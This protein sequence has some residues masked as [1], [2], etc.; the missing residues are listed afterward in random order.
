MQNNFKSGVKYDGGKPMMSL[1]PPRALRETAKVLT[2]GAQKYAPDNWRKLDNLQGRYLDAALRHINEFQ[3][4]TMV[5]EES[6]CPTLAHAICDLMFV[7][8]DLLMEESEAKPQINNTI[9]QLSE[10]LDD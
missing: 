2:F 8:E 3:T 1:V 7:L 6:G 9:M 5:D 10:L 4:G